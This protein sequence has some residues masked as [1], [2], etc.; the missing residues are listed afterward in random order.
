MSR[1]PSTRSPFSIA[2]TTTGKETDSPFNAV[3]SRG[4][5][6]SDQRP[7]FTPRNENPPSL[8]VVVS[9]CSVMK[10]I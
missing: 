4:S 10:N 2:R 8:N 9:I 3:T 1:S 6:M 7:G 5:T